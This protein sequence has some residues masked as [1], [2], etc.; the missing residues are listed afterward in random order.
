MKFNGDSTFAKSEKLWDYCAAW[1]NEMG[2]QKQK[3]IE[4]SYYSILSN[5]QD[6]I[7]LLSYCEFMKFSY[8]INSL[9]SYTPQRN[10]TDHITF[11]SRLSTMIVKSFDSKLHTTDIFFF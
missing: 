7:L 2:H 5:H 9:H 8:H 11:Y 10:F 3:R 4:E 6:S 1:L